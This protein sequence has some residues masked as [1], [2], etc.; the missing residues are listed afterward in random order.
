LASDRLTVE[1][2]TLM[3]DSKT[4]WK[5][6]GDVTNDLARFDVGDQVVTEGSYEGGAWKAVSVELMV[7]AV[8]DEPPA[9]PSGPQPPPVQPVDP[10]APVAT[11]GTIQSFMP[12]SMVLDTGTFMLNEETVWVLAD[13]SLGKPELFSVDD[14]VEVSAV[15]RAELWVALRVTMLLDIN[16]T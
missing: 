11:I 14:K 2:I 5:A 4:V 8:P 15:K 7:N 10:A 12:E 1:G 3:T 6:D 16:H 9:E 13:G